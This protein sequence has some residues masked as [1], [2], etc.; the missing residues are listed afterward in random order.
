MKSA[1]RMT[2]KTTTAT[3]N[4]LCTALVANLQDPSPVHGLESDTPRMHTLRSV[5][6][7]TTPW[8]SAPVHIVPSPTPRTRHRHPYQT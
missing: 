3:A 1:K 5:T 2:M 7:R 6:L 8:V 4:T